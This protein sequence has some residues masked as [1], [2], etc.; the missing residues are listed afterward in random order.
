MNPQI[1]QLRKQFNGYNNAQKKQFIDNLKAK[2]K[3]NNNADY[4][5]FLS[6]CVQNY[7][8]SIK[9]SSSGSRGGLSDF[10]DLLD[11]GIGAVAF[12]KRIE[13]YGANGYGLLKR[14]MTPH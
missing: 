7:N 1:E 6:E 10:D 4:S 12:E 14:G 3:T 5:R 8:A 2:L 13:E 11:V 9:A